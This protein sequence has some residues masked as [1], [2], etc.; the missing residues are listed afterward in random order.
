[1]KPD[2][3][4]RTDP[5]YVPDREAFDAY[6]HAEIWHSVREALDPAALGRTAEGWQAG[7]AALEQMFETFAAAVRQE[8]AEWHGRAA[9]SARES[10]E[11]FV[12]SGADAQ[13]VC[14]AV[15]RLMEVNSSA[16]QTVRD[17]IP[18]PPAPYVPDPDPV[19]EAVDGGPRK[20]ASD[21]AAAN[22]LAD[23][24]DTLTFLYNSTLVASGDA[25]P[26]FD[27]R[28]RGEFAP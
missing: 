28:A 27:V 25:V 14:T 18:P 19:R 13:Q 11:A 9:D 23:A 15:H 20:M 17:A 6:T 5:P 26:G 1:M 4:E 8:F 2:R 7:A 12:R 21:I 16:A 10:T 22:T 24:Q 3:P